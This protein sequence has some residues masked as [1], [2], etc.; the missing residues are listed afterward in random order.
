MSM[1]KAEGFQ[2]HL[3]YESPQI[4]ILTLVVLVCAD[5]NWK[6]WNYCSGMYFSKLE[7]LV[8]VFRFG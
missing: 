4:K 8:S 2:T 1:R 7:E 5:V 3:R 6:S